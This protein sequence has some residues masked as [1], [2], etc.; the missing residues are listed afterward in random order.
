MNTI[1]APSLVTPTL[2]QLF[3]AYFMVGATGFGSSVVWLRRI[4]VEN[5]VVIGF[6]RVSL[7][8][9]MLIIAPVSIL[10]AAS[11]KS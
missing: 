6:F 8:M 3:N 9:V 4:F 7:P 11:L 2:V 1:V 10:L 5:F